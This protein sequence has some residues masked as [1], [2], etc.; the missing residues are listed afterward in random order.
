MSA[1]LLERREE[2]KLALAERNDQTLVDTLLNWVNRPFQKN[3]AENEILSAILGTFMIYLITSFVGTILVVLLREYDK[4]QQI[5]FKVNWWIIPLLITSTLSMVVSNAF[6]RRIITIFRDDVLELVNTVET[7]NDIENWVRSIHNKK[8]ALLVSVI[9]GLVSGG[10]LVSNLSANLGFSLGIG[11]TS[12]IILFSMQSSLFVGFLCA[13]LSLTMQ[14]QHYH[15]ALFPSDPSNSQIVNTLSRFLSSFVYVFAFYGAFITFALATTGLLTSLSYV[16]P[17]FWCLIILIF[18]LNQYSLAQIIQREKWKTLNTLQEQIRTIQRDLISTDKDTRETL[19]WL[20]DYYERVK[21][22]PNS[23]LNLEAGLNLLN[24]L[25]L[26]VFAFLL[27][28]LDKISAFF[29]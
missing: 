12:M 25:L 7:L 20:L 19:T 11:F 10:W 18:A 26:P 6:L 17:M 8:L 5:V 9:G 15:L 14:M 28:N 16:L 1:N 29:P 4:L 23:T 2:L 13:V 3:I 22:T 27:G 21:K 24:S